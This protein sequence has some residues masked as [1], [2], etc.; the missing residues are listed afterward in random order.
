MDS[1]FLNERIRFTCRLELNWEIE[2]AIENNNK[3]KYKTLYIFYF[4]KKI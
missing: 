2:I 1:N 4:N 3:E